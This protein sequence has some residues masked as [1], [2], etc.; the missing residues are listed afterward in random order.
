MIQAFVQALE[1]S[2]PISR[3]LR[4]WEDELEPLVLRALEVCGLLVRRPM[5]EGER[6]PC[7]GGNHDGCPRRIIEMEDDQLVAVCGAVD[8]C[9]EVVIGPEHAVRL[10]ADARSISLAL[11]RLL[12]LRT[13]LHSSLRDGSLLVGERSFGSRRAAF[14]FVANPS[15]ALS[16]SI[17]E[18]LPKRALGGTELSAVVVPCSAAIDSALRQ[19]MH[20]QCT[21]CL[22]LEDCLRIEDGKIK[23]SL[24]RFI[25]DNR[26]R[27]DDPGADLWPDYWLVLDP[28]NSRYWL[29]G[30]RLDLESGTL[31][32]KFLELLAET[33]SKLVTRAHI[34][35]QLWPKSVDPDG[36]VRK[37]DLN[38]LADLFGSTVATLR[39]CV[40]GVEM[41][42]ELPFAGA[43]DRLIRTVTG[44]KSS[45]KGF[46]LELPAGRVVKWQQD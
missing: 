14:Y 39:R 35:K 31:S 8:Q 16:K 6:Y 42:K 28:P 13:G 30:K 24:G 33:P 1:R 37:R 3:A 45:P 41:P 9:D 20:N 23:V 7:S 15:T 12:G 26:L 18:G 2:F 17:I 5:R 38:M 44:A 22:S 21:A 25:L 32:A 46:I 11:S 29:A 27:V 36:P 10:E 40:G 19:T 4:N 43:P 34:A